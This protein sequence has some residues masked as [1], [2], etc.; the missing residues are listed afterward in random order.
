ML[1]RTQ[2][3]DKAFSKTVAAGF[4]RWAEHVLGASTVGLTPIGAGGLGWAIEVLACLLQYPAELEPKDLEELSRNASSDWLGICFLETMASVENPFVAGMTLSVALAKA[5][6]LAPQG[7]RRKLLSLQKKVDALLLE[8]LE[9]LPQTVHAFRGGMAGCSAVFEPEVK[10]DD[11]RGLLG[12]LPMI[13][14]GRGHMETFCTRPLIVDFLW[15]RF[16]HGIPDLLDTKGVLDDAEEIEMLAGGSIVS[17]EYYLL[18]EEQ[19]KIEDDLRLANSLGIEFKDRLAWKEPI[20]GRAGIFGALLSPCIMLQG[21]DLKDFS[22][23][24]LSVLPGA[25]F[26]LAGLAAMPDAFYRVPAMRMALDLLAYLGM[27]SVFSSVVLFHDTGPPTK[28]EFAFAF[29]ILVRMNTVCCRFKCSGLFV[30]GTNLAADEVGYPVVTSIPDFSHACCLAMFVAGWSHD[31]SARDEKELP[32]VQNGLLE[33]D[34]FPGIWARGSRPCR[35][36]R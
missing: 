26:I 8:I 17:N 11:A 7:E 16:T 24:S 19:K 31:G 27:V 13:C 25:Q 32:A 1:F 6:V 4:S 9:R 15:R 22:M 23:T 36:F 2:T 21:V 3:G 14:Q 5:A 29:Y 35:P 20:Q 30:V 28:H 18:T 12:P 10:R 34:R 33:S